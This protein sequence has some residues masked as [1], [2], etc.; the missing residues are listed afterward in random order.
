MIKGGKQFEAGV[1]FVISNAIMNAVIDIEP[2]NDRL[3]GLVLRG[4]PNMNIYSIYIPQAGR[5]TEDKES[6]YQ[7]LTETVKKTTHKGANYILGDFNPRV[8]MC[9][10]ETEQHVVGK[11]MFDPGTADPMNKSDNVIENRTLFINFCDSLQN[12]AANTYFKKSNEKLVTFREPSGQRGTYTRP[13]HEQIDYILVQQRWWNSILDTESY[14]KANINSDHYPLVA[15]VRIKLKA[16]YQTKA[17][18]IKF[19]KCSKEE[20]LNLNKKWASEGLQ[21]TTPYETIINAMQ[22]TVEA[23]LPKIPNN[24]KKEHISKTASDFLEER[25]KA[26]DTGNAETFQLYDKSLESS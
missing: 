13:G 22:A 5:D 11:H 7:I 21:E 18:R 17:R 20:Q 6:M 14:P 19:Q 8:Q 25:S 12:K 2:I 4:R 26:L 10:D 16:T 24:Q 23:Q 15:K 1:G 3:C 9:L